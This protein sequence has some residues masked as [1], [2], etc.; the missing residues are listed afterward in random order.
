MPSLDGWPVKALRP[1]RRLKRKVSAKDHARGSPLAKTTL[2]AYGDFTSPACAQTYRTVQEI[3]K[4]MG[5]RLRYVYRSFPQPEQYPHSEEA[6]EAAECA[7]AQGRFWEMHDSIFEAQAPTHTVRLGRHA[8]EA[9]LDVVRF[10]RE[11]RAHVYTERVRA[12]REGGVRSGV[13]A[14]PAFFINSLRHESSFGLATLLAALQAASGEE[15]VRVKNPLPASRKS[16]SKR[17][18]ALGGSPC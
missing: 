5:T 3:Q 4:E 15:S 9:G 11:M 17:Q 2:V 13:A 18:G 14:A 7:A 8:A 6:A 10:R 12:I 16:R 1:A